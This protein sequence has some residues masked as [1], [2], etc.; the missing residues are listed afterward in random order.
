MEFEIVRRDKIHNKSRSSNPL[1]VVADKNDSKRFMWCYTGLNKQG[2]L[3][4]TSMLP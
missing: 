3:I 2:A 1:K 4:I